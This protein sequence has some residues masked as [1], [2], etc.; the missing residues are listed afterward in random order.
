[1][2]ALLSPPDSLVFDLDGTLWDTCE[3]CARGWNAVL[4][5]HAMPFRRVT[6]D[7]VRRVA[8]RPHDQCIRDTFIG[9]DESQLRILSDETAEEDNRMIEEHGGVIYPGVAEGLAELVRVFP[10]FIVSNCQAGY[11]ELFLRKSGWA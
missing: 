5:R 11:I 7:D 9:L 2:N 6:A 8:G 1:M 10:L 3:S 4:E